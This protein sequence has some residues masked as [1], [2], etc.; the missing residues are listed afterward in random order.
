MSDNKL[1]LFQDAGLP[2]ADQMKQYFAGM[3]TVASKTESGNLEGRQLLR[4]LKADGSWVFGQEAEEIE[5]NDRIAVNPISI[6]HGFI[7]W[8]EG[9][10][11]DE[12]MVPVSQP[13]PSKES[14][15]AA[16]GKNGWTEQLQ[17]DAQ[18]F[19]DPDLADI[20]LRYKQNSLGGREAIR[21]LAK[22][23][24]NQIQNYGDYPVPVVQLTNTN[25]KHK[26][27]GIIYKPVFEVVK[28]ISFAGEEE[29]ERAAIEAPSEKGEE[30]EAA[31]TKRRRRKKA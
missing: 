27:Y 24:L 17:F 23:I 2:A 25:Y 11:A 19:G 6:M 9:Q 4:M 10:I 29:P 5:E 7:D 13:L 30:K 8:C 20:L 16:Q 21:A 14:L 15:G 3:Q 28:W 1:Q 18:F 12:V 31:P 22:Q 26:E